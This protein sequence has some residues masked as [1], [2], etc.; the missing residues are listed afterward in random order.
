M[1]KT[2]FLLTVTVIA[3]VALSGCGNM[4]E[5]ANTT[6]NAN[7]AGNA[8]AAGK[9]STTANKTDAPASSGLKPGDVTPDKAVKV[10]EL[11]DAATADEAAWKDKEVTVSGYVWEGSG[12]AENIVTV[13]ND[14]KAISTT[15]VSCTL[16]GKKPDGLAGKTV[17]FKGKISYVTKSGDSKSVNL[18]PCELKK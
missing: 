9:A 2:I 10:I 14:A 15:Q 13:T 18:N 4:A 8:N 7:T 5:K 3:M 16:Q 11:A 6:G 1:N 17:E 12:A